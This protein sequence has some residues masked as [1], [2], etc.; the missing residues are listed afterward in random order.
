MTT[1]G[2][3]VFKYLKERGDSTAQVVAKET[4]IDFE[5]VE[6]LWTLMSNLVSLDLTLQPGSITSSSI[7]TL[8]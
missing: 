3:K 7:S 4:G 6:N 8:N 5:I 1:E 2:R